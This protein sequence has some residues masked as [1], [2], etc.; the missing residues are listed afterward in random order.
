[1]R[2]MTEHGART[3]PAS[4]HDGLVAHD[5]QRF[6][7]RSDDPAV[8]EFMTMAQAGVYLGGI[9]RSS[10]ERLIEARELPHYRVGVRSLRIRR[11]DLDAYL[12][13]CRVPAA[14]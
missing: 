13:R 12:D 2:P 14:S 3:D 11:T 4:A 10:V 8:D 6:V 7:A 9:S 5:P 1:M